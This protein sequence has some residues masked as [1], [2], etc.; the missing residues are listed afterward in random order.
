MGLE[1]WNLDVRKPESNKSHQ[2][3]SKGSRWTTLDFRNVSGVAL[4]FHLLICFNNVCETLPECKIEVQVRSICV[5][6]H[7]EKSVGGFFQSLSS[8]HRF[9]K[10]VENN[11]IDFF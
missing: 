10:K 5:G 6:T 9:N 4:I 2:W 11:T 8:K 7:C 3:Y 1:S